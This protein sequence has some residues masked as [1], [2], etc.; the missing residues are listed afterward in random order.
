MSRLHDDAEKEIE[1]LHATIARLTRD[2]DHLL[3]KEDGEYI[4]ERLREAAQ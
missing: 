2:K 1:E 4:R 3:T